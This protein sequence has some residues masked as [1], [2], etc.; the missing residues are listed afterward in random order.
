[1]KKKDTSI[2][3]YKFL[4]SNTRKFSAAWRSL[5]VNNRPQTEQ[6][7]KP[8][9]V[10]VKQPTTTTNIKPSSNQLVFAGSGVYLEITQLLA[11]EF[12]KSHP[13]IE[14]YVP[15]SIGSTGAIQAVADG[16]IAVR[17]ISR[18][19]KEQEKKQGV[20]VLPYAQTPLA[21]GVHLAVAEDWITLEGLIQIY[22]GTKSHWQD[23]QDIQSQE[24]EKI[25]KANRY[26]AV[27]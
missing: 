19:L 10:P 23:G 16:A 22:K 26:L 8:D 3:Q 21:I 1:M 20:T 11:E 15:I 5:S 2:Y 27:E 7:S 24:V 14:I 12:R 9:V 4:V 6:I 25:P 17:M 13:K 18:L